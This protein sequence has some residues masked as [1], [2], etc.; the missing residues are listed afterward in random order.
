MNRS[1]REQLIDKLIGEAVL[2]ILYDNG[3]ISTRTLIERL[4]TMEAA[5]PEEQ[6]RNVIADVIA[7]IRNHR[8]GIS[9]RTL[10]P[11]QKPWGKESQIQQDKNVY[12]L[13]D[14]SPMPGSSKKH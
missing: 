12:P 1:K 9:R 8:L 4:Q 13:F 14:D 2:S 5:E 11:A 10:A 7:D 3:A 6:R